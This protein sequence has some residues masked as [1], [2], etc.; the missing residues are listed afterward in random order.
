M[1]LTRFEIVI[2]GVLIYYA[3]IFISLELTYFVFQYFIVSQCDVSQQQ[4]VPTAH[5]NRIILHN[6]FRSSS[7]PFTI[8]H[9]RRNPIVSHAR[10]FYLR[11]ACSKSCLG[12][13]HHGA[14]GA[15]QRIKTRRGLGSCLRS[16][17]TDCWSRSSIV[18]GNGRRRGA[19]RSRSAPTARRRGGGQTMEAGVGRHATVWSCA[20]V[21][22]R[23]WSRIARSLRPHALVWQDES[24]LR[25]VGISWS[26]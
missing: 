13:A 11:N 6:A 21:W 22:P 25:G 15:P 4:C 23:A 17:A 3:C 26:R 19:A 8:I 14:E 18:S 7:A 20:G 5:I 16:R 9:I 1:I 12:L 2:I 10:F 24:V